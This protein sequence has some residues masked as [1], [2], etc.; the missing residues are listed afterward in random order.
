ML[1]LETLEQVLYSR[2]SV[3]ALDNRARHSY[4]IPRK[5]DHQRYKENSTS[6]TADSDTS[7]NRAALL[8]SELVVDCEIFQPLGKWFLSALYRSK[9][10]VNRKCF[11]ARLDHGHAWLLFDIFCSSSC[12]LKYLYFW[13]LGF[14][15]SWKLSMSEFIVSWKCSVYTLCCWLKLSVVALAN[16][17]IPE[18]SPES[19]F[20]LQVEEL[21]IYP[22]FSWIEKSMT[23]HL[24]TVRF[25]RLIY[26][27]YS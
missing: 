22:A 5:D 10:I 9:F 21:A 14:R 6:L 2:N 15:C 1:L 12:E 11:V 20:P 17:N 8:T 26:C 13:N 19:V 25:M 23:Y 18:F 16:W 3:T 4:C 27:F 24:I 7:V